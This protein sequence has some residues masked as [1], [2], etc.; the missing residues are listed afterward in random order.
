MN[1]QLAKINTENISAFVD[2]LKSLSFF[3]NDK[4]IFVSRSPG[5][6]DI[7]G[8]IADYS[9]SLMLEMPIREATKVALQ[10]SKSRIIEIISESNDEVLK[11]EMPLSDFFVDRK[12]IDYQNAQNYFNQNA[13]NHWASYI[14][15]VFLVLATEKAIYFNEGVKI[16][17]SSEIPLGKGVSSSAALEVAVIQAV[18]A[19]FGIEFDSRE[20]AILCQKVENLVVGAACG[21]M[22]QMSV[23][24]GQENKL[25]S[26]LCQSAEIQDWLEIP[27]DIEFWGID[28]GVRHAVVGADYSSVRIGAFMGYRIIC[29]LAE[30]DVKSTEINHLVEIDDT[31]WNGFLCNTTPSEFEQFYAS[32]LPSEILG[33]EFLAKYQGTSDSVT[34]INPNKIY[35]VK[36]P[37]K[38]A[39]YE[40]FRVKMF[41]EILK[42]SEPNLKLLGELMFQAHA[43]YSACGL[44]ELGTNRIVELVR[45]DKATNLF[46]AKITGGGSGGT[47]AVLAKK[48]SE[49]VI[50]E[51]VEK[52]NTETGKTPYIFKGSSN[53]A[54]NFGTLKISL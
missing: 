43:S 8:G 13:D 45:Q 38:H 14:C 50:E 34:T 31:K 33:S 10:K 5:R 41:G 3:E 6:L 20:K 21:V 29:E 16:Y 30:F 23:M 26:L 25:F 51:L 1:Q 42:S 17:I 40:N 48:G 27:S 18:C 4:D 19:A 44:G 39:I 52:Y 49:K 54:E 24:F 46:G 53:G 11:F 35:A 28:S 2:S 36:I 9:G 7:M 22:D 47:V 15:G 37:T 32:K 12:L